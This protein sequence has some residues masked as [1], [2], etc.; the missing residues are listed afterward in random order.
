MLNSITTLKR[1]QSLSQTVKAIYSNGNFFSPLILYAF[2]VMCF[3]DRRGSPR[4]SFNWKRQVHKE[5]NFNQTILN[6]T[7]WTTKK[8]NTQENSFLWWI[9]QGDS[10]LSPLS[11]PFLLL[12]FNEWENFLKFNSF[13]VFNS[14]RF[15]FNMFTLQNGVSYSVHGI[16][17][18]WS[19]LIEVIKTGV[20]RNWKCQM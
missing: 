14:L 4:I 2:D 13:N 7:E 6:L 1:L 17:C 15:S 16:I 20:T 3:A 8:E 10:T 18:N 9:L 12:V 11:M 5:T 19:F